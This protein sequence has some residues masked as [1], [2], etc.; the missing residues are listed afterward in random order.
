MIKGVSK[1]KVYYIIYKKI[2]ITQI[3]RL[4]INNNINNNINYISVISN[5]EIAI[6]K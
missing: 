4:N 2:N 3:T 5:N 1:D 6:I